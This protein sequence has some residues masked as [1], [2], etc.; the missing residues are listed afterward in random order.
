MTDLSNSGFSPL[1]TML[2]QIPWFEWPVYAQ[3]H[4]SPSSQRNG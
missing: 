1:H 4:M 2:T 3:H